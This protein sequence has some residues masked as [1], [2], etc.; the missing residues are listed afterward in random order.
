MTVDPQ[1]RAG[2]ASPRG[3]VDRNCKPEKRI[4]DTLDI[5]EVGD[6]EIEFERPVSYPQP[7]ALD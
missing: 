7:A 1:D 4:L 6:I 5:A 2:K 3:V